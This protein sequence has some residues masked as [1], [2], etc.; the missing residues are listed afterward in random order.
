MPQNVNYLIRC[1]VHP[2]TGSCFLNKSNSYDIQ[3]VDFFPPRFYIDLNLLFI[4]L[5]YL[6]MD[7]GSDQQNVVMYFPLPERLMSG[8]TGYL[9]IQFAESNVLFVPFFHILE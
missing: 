2:E 9:A 4:H 5:A 1:E 7:I 8:F 3:S 6:I